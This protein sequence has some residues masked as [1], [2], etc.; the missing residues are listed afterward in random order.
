ML[1]S[2]EGEFLA[3]PDEVLVTVMRDHQKYFALEDAAGKLSPHFLAVLNT[4][5]DPDGLIATAMSGCCAP[6]SAMPAFS[7]TPTRRSPLRQRVDMLKSV[8]FQ[9]DLGSYYDK[10]DAGAELASRWR[11]RFAAPA[12]RSGR[13]S[14][15]RRRCWQDRSDGRAGE[16]VHR[17]ARH[18]RRALR[19]GTGAR[20][21]S[22]AS[23]GG[24]HRRRHL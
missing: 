2:F 13:A 14:C 3:L 11:K 6:A 19:Q 8:T 15:S 9:K 24:S 4:A 5:G 16:G 23:D 1:G 10:T 17:V 21:H 22:A 18:R 7:G 20:P 12:A